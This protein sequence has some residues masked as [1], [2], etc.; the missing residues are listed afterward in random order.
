[1]SLGQ[2]YKFDLFST[3][4]VS[5]LV[6]PLSF[7]P[8]IEFCHKAGNFE[9]LKLNFLAKKCRICKPGLGT[10][11][12]I[13]KQQYFRYIKRDDL[14]IN[15][16]VPE[17]VF[18]TGVSMRSWSIIWPH[19]MMFMVTSLVASASDLTVSNLEAR[20]GLGRPLPREQLTRMLRASSRR[21]GYD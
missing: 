14:L 6:E 13:N 1:M 4:C 20:R 5:W 17:T 18:L 8:W 3:I 15:F 9:E 19:S 12:A 7:F 11:E 21:Y 16:Q 2:A 10:S